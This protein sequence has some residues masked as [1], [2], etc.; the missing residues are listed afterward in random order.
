MADKFEELRRE[1]TAPARDGRVIV[2]DDGNDLEYVA[3]SI[4]VGT[5][6]IVNV[7]SVEGTTLPFKMTDGGVITMEVSRVLATGTTATD[8]IA[9]I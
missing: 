9:Y 3:R 7:V 8:L 2:P 4:H 6:G 5:A 1:A